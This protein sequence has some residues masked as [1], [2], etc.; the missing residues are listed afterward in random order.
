M[1]LFS[2][3]RQPDRTVLHKSHGGREGKGG[4]QAGYGALPPAGIS[5]GADRCR[6]SAPRT[7][8][9]PKVMHTARSHAKMLCVNYCEE[10]T[11]EQTSDSLRPEHLV[12]KRICNA[13]SLVKKYLKV[14][15][16]FHVCVLFD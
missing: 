13:L 10:T 16:C 15:S 14:V 6:V 2:S 8:H 9:I 5:H 3:R 12:R 11:A 7:S 1:H 4:E